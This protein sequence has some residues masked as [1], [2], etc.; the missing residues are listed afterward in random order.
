VMWLL[1][2]VNIAGLA[3]TLLLCEE[4]RGRALS[5]T[6]APSPESTPISDRVWADDLLR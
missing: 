6:S 5:E 2:G 3:V 1:A 4:T